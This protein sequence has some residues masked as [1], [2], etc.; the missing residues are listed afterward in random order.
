MT[1]RIFLITAVLTLPGARAA[2]KPS[3]P[4]QSASA[5]ACA[6]SPDNAAIYLAALAKVV[7]KDR[8]DKRQIVLLSQTSAG[9]PPGMAAF[10]A[11]STPE[12]KELLDSASAATK[13]DFDAKAKLN[14]DLTVNAELSAA[15]VFVS[16]QES[17][18]LLSKA[19]GWKDFAQKY[20]NAAGFTIVSAIAFDASH[21]QALV[22]VGNSCGMLCGTGYVVLLEKKKDKWIVAKTAKIWNAT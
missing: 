4:A 21:R 5:A 2:E 10:T 9:Y 16:P 14:C 20:P 19:S 7:L 8:N 15:V 17:D 18:D 11:S 6:T 13:N 3:R 22:Y 12:K 1:L